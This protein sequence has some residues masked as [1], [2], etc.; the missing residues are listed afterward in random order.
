MP[1][2]QKYANLPPIRQDIPGLSRKSLI[3]KTMPIIT[4][5]AQIHSL[6]KAEKVI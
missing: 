3:L 2:V 5:L 6:E 4:S 1:Q